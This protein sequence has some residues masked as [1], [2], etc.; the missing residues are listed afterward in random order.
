MQDVPASDFVLPLNDFQRLM[1]Y[2]DAVHPF[3]GIDVI[4]SLE[5]VDAAKLG[6]AAAEELAILGTGWPSASANGKSV[7]YLTDAAQVE[8]EHVPS[9]V[10]AEHCSRELNRPFQDGAAPF[11]RIWIVEGTPHAHIGMTWQHWP[12]DGVSAAELFR[13][14]LVRYAGRP[15]PTPS[16]ATERILPDLATIY[17][18]WQTWRRKVTDL[19]ITLTELYYHSRIFVVP[20]APRDRLVYRVR[21]L[22][23]PHPARP[24]GAT[25]NDVIAAALMWALLNAL[26]ARQRKLWRR[27]INIIN[28]VDL[29]P[30][31]GDVLQRAWGSFLGYGTLFM[32][33]P[34]PP[35]W[36]DLIEATRQQSVRMR[37][38][39]LFF[40]SLGGFKLLRTA[41]QLLPRRWSW[42]LPYLLCP[43]TAALTNTRFRG[44]WSSD[45][46]EFP[47]GRSWRVAP[48]GPMV[49]LSVDVCTKGDQMSIALTYEDNSFLAEKID[50]IAG[51]LEQLLAPGR[52]A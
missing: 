34:C 30:F 13:R 12:I 14:I 6:L 39:T 17:R 37:E 40:T 24:P 38:H 23:L 25:V 33:E 7:R 4:E 16:P 8:V 15:A 20:R 43:F 28:F 5:P 45:P 10:L 51:T 50:A 29:R 46:R 31:G 26:E 3:S 18:P 22:D 1:R 42:R 9:A 47:F 44:E 2:W 49:P 21:L 27:R 32:P 35:R 48:V 41:W 52:R 11:I 19:Y 36:E